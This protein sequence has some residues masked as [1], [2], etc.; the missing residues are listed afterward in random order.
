[1]SGAALALTGIKEAFKR[2]PNFLTED[3]RA[4]EAIQSA[5]NAPSWCEGPLAQDW[6]DAISAFRRHIAAMMGE[7]SLGGDV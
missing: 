3:V 2:T 5:M 6:E 7:T 1:M 4:V